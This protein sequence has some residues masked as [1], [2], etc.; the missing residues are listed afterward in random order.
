MLQE[1][2]RSHFFII[3]VDKCQTQRCEN[4]GTCVNGYGTNGFTCYCLE[5]TAG[6][7]YE[8]G[9]IH[10]TNLNSPLLKRGSM[11]LQ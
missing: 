1:S 9:D 5:G 6:D 3:S 7:T 4:G 11:H 10:V 2:I 8:T